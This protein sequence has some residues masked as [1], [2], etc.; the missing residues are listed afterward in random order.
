MAMDGND[1][2]F[3]FFISEKNAFLVVSFIG[4]LDTKAMDKLS[5]LQ[6]EILSKPQARNIILNFRDATNISGDAIQFLT[7][8]QRDIRVKPAELR[9]CGLNPFFK[10]KL[11]KLGILRASE[12][13]DNLNIAIQSLAQ[14][15]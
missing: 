2:E 11:G 7:Y 1:T 9:I 8:L 4:S 6:S 5:A 13:V 14:K 3:E 15:K 10:E 12:L